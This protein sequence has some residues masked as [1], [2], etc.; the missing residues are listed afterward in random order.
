[1]VRH[2]WVCSWGWLE[3]GNGSRAYY[4]P[5]LTFNS[6]YKLIQV[7]VHNVIEVVLE[8]P[9]SLSLVC[10]NLWYLLEDLVPRLV[11]AALIFRIRSVAASLSFFSKPFSTAS[12]ALRAHAV[13]A[14]AL[15]PNTPIVRMPNNANDAAGMKITQP[16]PVAIKPATPPAIAPPTRAPMDAEIAT[17]L[18][19]RL[20]SGFGPLE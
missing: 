20:G 11:A 10:E 9:V 18:R 7:T 8:L 14:A 2:V 12:L 17:A 3:R 13:P 15:S 1:M 5:I 16:M 19:P 6:L 4:L